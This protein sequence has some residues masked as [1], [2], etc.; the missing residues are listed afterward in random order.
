MKMPL[1]LV[2]FDQKL[3]EKRKHHEVEDSL[4][5]IWKRYYKRNNLRFDPY[6]L[7]PSE[8]EKPKNWIFDTIEVI[9]SEPPYK[10]DVLHKVGWIKSQAFELLGTC[11][12]SDL[13]CIFVNYF[14]CEFL[15]DYTMAMPKDISRRTYANWPEIKE[16]LNAGFIFQN[17]KLI[18]NKFK[19]YWQ[20]KSEFS[21]ITYF[22]EIIFSAILYDI[23][24][25]ILDESFN[26]SWDINQD[27]TIYSKFFEKNNKI[28]HFNGIRKKNIYKLL[29]LI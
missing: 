14:D 26:V 29:Q 22:D 24:G 6:L 20:S 19:E 7:L 27:K 11:V 13:D 28:I 21:K 9:D 10:L 3:E 12:V 8:Q 18:K 25:I 23:K 1:A 5:N 4:V 16:E 15:K 2:Y 17:S